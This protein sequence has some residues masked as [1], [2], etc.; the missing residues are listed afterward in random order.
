MAEKRGCHPGIA[1]RSIPGF[2]FSLDGQGPEVLLNV[3]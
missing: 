2:I 1:L 3:P